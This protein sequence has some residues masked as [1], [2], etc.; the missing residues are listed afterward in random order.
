MNDTADK[1]TGNKSKWTPEEREVINRFLADRLAIV[2]HS[3]GRIAA[4][5]GLE[6]DS[7]ACR[8]I[9]YWRWTEG[10]I[11]WCL[12]TLNQV[13]G[14]KNGVNKRECENGR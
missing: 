7:W 1:K 10:F 12:E 6:T 2:H 8:T 9:K 11:N 14:K 5:S 13:K 3:M 4:L